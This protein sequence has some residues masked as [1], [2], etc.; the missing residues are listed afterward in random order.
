MVSPPI[1]GGLVDG[2]DENKVG[3]TE[4]VGADDGT[5]SYTNRVKIGS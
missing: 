1:E 5:P 4:V 3:E 2:G